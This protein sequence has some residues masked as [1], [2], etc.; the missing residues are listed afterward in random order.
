MTSGRATPLHNR[1]RRNAYLVPPKY[2][3]E[4]HRC[5]ICRKP[6]STLR[7]ATRKSGK[8]KEIMVAYYCVEHEIIFPFK[9]VV[10]SKHENVVV[11]NE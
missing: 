10:I 8:R 1:T 5:S 2:S 9:R 7:H 4:K 3:G 6:V 11:M